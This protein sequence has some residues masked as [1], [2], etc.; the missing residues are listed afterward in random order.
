MPRV[1]P[2]LVDHDSDVPRKRSDTSWPARSATAIAPPDGPVAADGRQACVSAGDA[3]SVVP[4]L[5]ASTATDV[6]VPAVEPF[7]PSTTTLSTCGPAARPETVRA[8]R[9]DADDA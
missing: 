6:P 9:Y 2:V 4:T 1:R 7:L 3:D 8:T 5:T